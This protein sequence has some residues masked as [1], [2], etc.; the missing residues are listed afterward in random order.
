M[1]R[2]AKFDPSF[3]IVLDAI[4]GLSAIFVVM[5]H[6]QQLGL[7][8]GPWPFSEALQCQAVIV[9]F[10]LSGLVIAN[11]TDPER[12]TLGDYAIARASRILPVAWPALAIS[13][14]LALMAPPAGGPSAAMAGNESPLLVQTLRAFFFLSES[15]T[16]VFDPNLPVWSLNYEVWFYI[17]FGAAVWL[18]GANRIFW[19]ALLAFLAGPRILV[20]LPA[21]LAGVWLAR[22]LR[23]GRPGKGKAIAM[24]LIGATALFVFPHLATPVRT[25]IVEQL[26]W[27]FGYSNKFLTDIPLA[28]ATAIGLKGLH[29]LCMGPIAWIERWR[30]PA[31]VLADMSFSLYILHWPL[32]NAAQLMGVTGLDSMGAFAAALAA[33]AL[34]CYLFAAATEHKRPAIR[35]WM[36]QRFQDK[37]ALA[38]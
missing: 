36:K 27:S 21:W 26:P 33:I 9:F 30:H 2:A 5:G 8:T 15:W 38:A 20:L 35:A 4:R 32:I 13:V 17:L 37:A 3:S 16:S 6:A 31:R 11:S 24:V 18:R 12:S 34:V 7:Y 25:N 23:D 29:A 14:L 19:L 28:F 10:V 1:V 22:E